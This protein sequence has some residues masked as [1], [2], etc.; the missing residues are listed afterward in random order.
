[1]G[2]NVR[3]NWNGWQR[4]LICMWISQL[5]VNTGFAAAFSFIALYLCENKFGIAEGMRGY[6]TSRFFFFGM[7]A[8]AIFTP[9][10][11][12]L[13]DRFGVK[14]MLYRGS[15]VTA[16]I[17]PLM[18][19]TTNVNTLI[20]MRF[21]TGALSGTTVAAKMLLVKTVPNDRQGFAL[22]V[23]ETSIWGGAMIGDV[24]GGL[25]V[26]KFGFT[27]TFFIC[28]ALFFVSGLFV[29]F[30]RDSEKSV[31]VAAAASAAR[32]GFR[33]KLSGM[34]WLVFPPILMMMVLFL[35]CGVALRFTAPYTS[36][37]VK[38]FVGD[39]KDAAYWTGI[40]GACAAGGGMLMGVLV[41]W[42][43]DKF[44]EWKITTPVQIASALLLFFAS[45]A[46]SLFGFG[47]CHAANSTATGGLYAV[48]QKVTSGL[49]ERVRRGAVLGFA[50]TMYNVGYMLS[51]LV[52]GWVV[53]RF[54]LCWVYR[55]ASLLMLVLAAASGL[56]IFAA[57]RF[58]KRNEDKEIRTT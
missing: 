1:M 58:K 26:A 55:S 49:V 28:G 56:A 53:T 24:L 48:F 19:L 23:L 51:T 11:G 46:T 12:M 41:G 4:N 22:G 27:A 45:G 32:P 10:W 39:H 52:S 42:L 33:E 31:A 54:G 13:S 20:V 15:F 21:L 30:A 5:L 36:L 14:I 35:L 9:I 17:Y 44:P 37:M 40:I 18:G 8:Y 16:L 38:N 43:S 50:T 7:L 34:R 57:L 2:L 25:A 29:I 3:D 6:Y 47:F